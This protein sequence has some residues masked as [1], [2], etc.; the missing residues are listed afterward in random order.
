MWVDF[1]NWLVRDDA[2]EMVWYRFMCNREK[3]TLGDVEVICHLFV[4]YLSII[5]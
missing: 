5:Y 4:Q 1:K 3:V 2:N